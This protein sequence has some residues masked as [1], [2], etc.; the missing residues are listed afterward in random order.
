MQ[1]N[2]RKAKILELLDGT[3][4][5]TAMEVAQELSITPINASRLL[6][7]YFRQGLLKRRTIN[8][9]GEQCYEITEKGRVRLVWL[10]R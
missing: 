9:F 1:R 7:H 4:E 10:L 2:E 6:G 3:G 8:K 5:A